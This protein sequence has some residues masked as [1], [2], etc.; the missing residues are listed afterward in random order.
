[1][2]SVSSHG[3]V[4]MN[5]SAKE[6]LFRTD[7]RR[8]AMA[9]DSNGQTRPLS[10]CNIYDVKFVAGLWRV[11]N[12]FEHKIQMVRGQEFVLLEKLNRV[13]KNLFEFYR[14]GVV[15]RN[16]YGRFLINGADLIVA[17]YETDDE[18]FWSYGSTI[19]QAR[20]FMGIRLYDKYQDLIH[21]TACKNKTK[22]K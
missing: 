4:A 16:C 2:P 13:E 3:L 6:L 14:A 10:E 22:T 18:T 1:M 21:A 20:A 17:K 7:C 19:E 11:Q 15:G 8:G 5:D 9:I 12:K